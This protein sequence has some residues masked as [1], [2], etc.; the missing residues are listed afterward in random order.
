MT[1]IFLAVAWSAGIALAD[2]LSL[3]WQALLVVGLSGVVGAIAWRD[4]PRARLAGACTV[5]LAQGAF[6]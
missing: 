6:C 1:L 4:S 5:V 2:A 3:L